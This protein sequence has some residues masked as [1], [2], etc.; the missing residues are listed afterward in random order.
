MPPNTISSAL[1]AITRRP[2]RPLAPRR[3]VFLPVTSLRH[4][5][6]VPPSSVPPGVE[7]PKIES[8]KASTHK[9]PLHG[10][11]YTENSTHQF[12]QPKPVKPEYWI[13]FTCTPC[14]HRSSH[15]ISKQ[16]YHRG[17]VLITCPEC[18][19]RHVISDHLQIFGD[20]NMTIEDLMKE[21]GQLVKKGTLSEDGDLEFWEDGTTTPTTFRTEAKQKAILD[22]HFAKIGRTNE[23]N[24]TKDQGV[25]DVEED[26]GMAGR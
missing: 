22:E 24:T 2:L 23:Q 12:F 26:P 11:Q 7:T 13:T 16:G 18:R 5:S 3:S 14:S 19:N 4:Y 21:R 15:K 6:D 9:R 17:S 1:R 20:K 10:P 25:E 8:P